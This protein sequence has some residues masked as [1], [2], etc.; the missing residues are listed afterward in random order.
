M[1]KMRFATKLSLLTGV[2]L[3]MLVVLVQ[4]FSA[5]TGDLA[6]TRAELEGIARVSSSTELIRPL[7]THRGQTN[8]VLSGNTAAQAD[9]DATHVALREAHEALD[10]Q[11][12]SSLAPFNS[13]SWTDQRTKVDALV[14]ALEGKSPQSSFA[15]HTALI[16]DWTRFTYGL[17]NEFSLLIEPDPA[18]FLLMGM[19][20]SRTLPW[21]EL[22]GKLRCQ[23]PVC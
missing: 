8:M 4:F 3:P 21:N 12:A 7:Q 23:G 9:R 5:Q 1:R 13:N 2:L 10:A 17:A 16:D 6:V 18:I 14:L 19:V 20:V 11:F 15:L 22:L